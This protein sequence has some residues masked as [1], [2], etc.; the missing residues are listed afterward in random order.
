MQMRAIVSIVLCLVLFRA[1]LFAQQAPAPNPLARIAELVRAIKTTADERTQDDASYELVDAANALR[2]S[3]IRQAPDEVIDGLAS[4]LSSRNRSVVYDV[5][6]TLS[7]FRIRAL[8]AVPA[9]RQALAEFRRSEEE[10]SAS[11]SFP[12]FL[13]HGSDV[14]DAVCRALDAIGAPSDF[15]NCFNG[16]FVYPGQRGPSPNLLRW[17]QFIRR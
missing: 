13:R 11:L 14:G 12:W 9:L 10:Y 15:R 6:Y 1:P 2:L 5:A 4:L 7:V 3:D 17:S 8:R 16:S